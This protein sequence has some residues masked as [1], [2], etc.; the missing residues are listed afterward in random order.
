MASV[1]LILNIFIAVLEGQ[2]PI[3][4][5]ERFHHI[6]LRCKS[7]VLNGVWV[8]F[9]WE[10]G[11][12]HFLMPSVRFYFGVSVLNRKALSG[13]IFEKELLN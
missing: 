13:R 6:S 9:L 2:G 5:A 11:D 4:S 8:Y 7:F 10:A 12:H 3:W 1:Y